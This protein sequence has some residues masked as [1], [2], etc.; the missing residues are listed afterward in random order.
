MSVA[1]QKGPNFLK[2][3]QCSLIGP[4]DRLSSQDQCPTKLGRGGRGWGIKYF[5]VI[6]P[7]GLLVLVITYI[8]F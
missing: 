6:E 8:F 7:K 4:R 5:V 1:C 3:D 2:S